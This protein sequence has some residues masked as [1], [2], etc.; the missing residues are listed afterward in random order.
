[1]LDRKIIFKIFALVGRLLFFVPLNNFHWNGNSTI[2]FEGLQIE[3]Y[4]WCWSWP[5]HRELLVDALTVLHVQRIYMKVFKVTCEDACHPPFGSGI[6]T[7]WFK[8]LLSLSL[9]G[10]EHPTF[11]HH[12]QKSTTVGAGLWCTNQYWFCFTKYM[13]SYSSFSLNFE[14]VRII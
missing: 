9:L 5:G 6:V 1:M 14:S 2:A 7:T 11:P 12:R 8:D 10:I 13:T 4:D 3:T